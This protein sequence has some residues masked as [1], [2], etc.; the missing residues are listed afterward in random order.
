MKWRYALTL[1]MGILLIL[2]AGCSAVTKPDTV[3]YVLDA[4][5]SRLDPAM[6]TVVTDDEVELQIFEGLT[7]MDEHDQPQPA[8]AKSWEI[9]PDG[10]TYTFHLR[11]GIVWSDGTPITAQDFE[12]SWKRV[13]N[14]DIA[15][16]NSYM[17]FPIE[18][19][20][21]YF[22]G[23]AKADEVG[24]K[25]LDDKTLQVKLQNPTAYFL[26]LTA[27]HC[28]YPV[29]KALVEAKPDTWAADAEGLPSCGPFKI[30]K[31]VHSSEIHLE[32][33]EKYWDADKVKLSHM[34]FPISD[35]QATRLTL[36]ESNQANMTV[37]PPPADQERLERLGLYKVVPYLGIY[38][39]VFNVTK[40]PF[41][42]V[43]VRRAFALAMQRESL[44]KNIVRGQKE[45]AYGWVPFGIVDPA[46]GRDFR[47]EGGKLAR[48]DAD[49][50]KKLLQE[51][52]YDKNHSLPPVTLLFNTNEI[53]KAIAEATQAMW[54]ENLGIQVSLMN[55]ESKVFV[56]T[57]SKGDYQIARASWT[58]DYVD[59]LSFME[60]FSDQA[61]DAQY[62]NEAYNALIKKAKETDNQAVR[63]AAMHEAEQILF[64]DCV[65]IPIYY[66][67]QPYVVQPYVKG[68]SCSLLGLVDFKEAYVE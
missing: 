21:D 3:K 20:E 12:Y 47:E 50:A 22:N 56:S 46:T 58:A 9:S 8:L 68:Y 54:K 62:H 27:F 26:N 59:P 10:K 42:D 57:R 14:P 29:P 17:M 35:S 40:P 11:D 39:Y 2:C 7:R 6:T 41:D 18:Q 51:A 45:A 53:N 25:A 61:N 24:I 64:D 15:S 55:Q 52:G 63:M 65:I 66:T 5:P 37:E 32:K 48:E 49:L 38:Y 19:A 60:V 4:E 30:T 1:L 36:V 33:N 16:E 31:W 23:K 34:E 43:R 13:V 28:Y 67:T 44:V